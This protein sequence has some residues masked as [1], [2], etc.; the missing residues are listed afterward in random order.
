MTDTPDAPANRMLV[1]ATH[2]GL[3]QVWIDFE[4][5]LV[6]VPVIARLTSGRLRIEEY[7][8]LLRNLRQQVVEGS[9]W[10]SRAAS[11]LGPDHEELRSLF[12]RHAVAEH[13]DYRLLEQNY[14]AAG[15]TA[16]DIRMAPKNIG[17][18][19]LSAFM[20]Q[21]ASRP[22]P[23]GMLGAM[24]VIEGLGEKLATPWAEAIRAQLGLGEEATS[25]LA[26][27][28]EN[29]GGHLDTFDH[30]LTLAVTSPTVSGDIVRHAKIV[31]R[32]YRLQLEELDNV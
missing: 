1:Q 12:V 2:R 29:D 25:F 30:A 28:G 3:A 14:V 7:R 9:R 31:A 6:Q 24:F 5:A 23:L 20:Y 26:Y 22:D 17:S 8:S 4:S 27:H 10:I 19:A 13:R 21:A 16:E 15:G 18:E 11:S 32:L